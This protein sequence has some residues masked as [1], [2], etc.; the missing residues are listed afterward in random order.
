MCGFRARDGEPDLPGTKVLAD[1]IVHLISLLSTVPADAG[2]HKVS[3][4]INQI[5]TTLAP[6]G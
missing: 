4:F 5:N 2:G 3:V 1:T 6:P